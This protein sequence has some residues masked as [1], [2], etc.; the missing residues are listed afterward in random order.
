LAVLEG[1]VGVSLYPSGIAAISGA[2]LALLK[3]GDEVLVVDNVYKPV[4]RFCDGV[5]TRFGI[6][7]SYFDPRTAPEALVGG[8]SQATRMILMESPGSLSFEMQDVPRIAD[9]VRGRPLGRV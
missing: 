5:L 7:V 9:Q 2:M 6:G 4:R 8:A 1:A 3:S